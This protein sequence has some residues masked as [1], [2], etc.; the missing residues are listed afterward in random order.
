MAGARG[1][2]ASEADLSLSDRLRTRTSGDPAFWNFATATRSGG[3]ALFQY[4][5]MMV[6]AMQG[7]LLD[8]LA[9]VDPSVR[10]VYDPFVGSGTVLLESLYRGMS[11]HGTDINPLAILLCQVKAQPPSG[12]V[13]LKAGTRVIGRARR[14]PVPVLP[15]FFGRDKWFD[16]SVAHDLARL[17]TSIQAERTLLIRRFLWIC[18]AETIRLVSNSRTST[19]KLHIYEPS[20]LRTRR[21]DAIAT[22]TDVVSANAKHVQVHWERLGEEASARATL[23]Q[24]SVTSR[25]TRPR[26]ADAIMTSP[27][28]GDNKT[29]VPYG[30]H[31]YLPL[32][33]IDTSDIPGG[34]D[35]ELLKSTGT[36]DSRSLGGS[37]VGAEESR[38]ALVAASSSFK[39]FIPRL[40]GKP[41]LEKKVLAFVRDY[42][43]GLVAAFA[44]LRKGG[45]SF[46][47]LGE[48][49]VG[50]HT[51][52]LVGITRELLEHNG[53]EFVDLVE[54]RLS[55]KRMA[56]KN[57]EG[58]TMATET[59]LVMKNVRP[60]RRPSAA[61]R[62][63]PS[64]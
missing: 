58:S 7:A 5:A 42:E 19:F 54:R 48:R 52:P 41:A 31:S 57:S 32:Q 56:T 39:R 26:R 33:W 61:G 3:H 18:L 17:R 37:L 20:M 35:E 21:P 44:N 24:G 8:D 30:Q 62:E 63:V 11:F 23:L 12:E 59:V 2:A 25:W 15:E 40:A 51:M 29:T 9:Q 6:P 16:P 50:G 47:T 53:Q 10:L 28:Y 43:L 45:Y 60:T 55:R 49:R 4:P 14:S 46:L 36:I 13:A 64:G 34:L 27:P 1:P 22:F 38:A